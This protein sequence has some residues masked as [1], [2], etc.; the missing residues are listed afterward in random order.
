[1]SADSR[2]VVLGFYASEEEEYAQRAWQAIRSLSPPAYY[3]RSDGKADSSTPVSE[4]YA[5]LRLS[6]EELVVAEVDSAQVPAVVTH[7][8]TA[9][10]PGVFVARPDELSPVAGSGPPSGAKS[11]LSRHSQPTIIYSWRGILDRLKECEAAIKSARTDLLK[12]NRLDHVITESAKWLLDNTYL[13][14][15]SIAEIRRSLPRGFRQAL[16]RFASPDGN[17]HICELARS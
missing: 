9:G 8:R 5:L 10:E 1:M 16:S 13:L 3:Y 14:R 12:A 15:A 17:L 4:K 6:D 2:R 11:P 7:L